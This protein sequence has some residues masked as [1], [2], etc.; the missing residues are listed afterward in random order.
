MGDKKKLSDSEVKDRSDELESSISEYSLILRDAGE[1]EKMAASILKRLATFEA[2][3]CKTPFSRGNGMGRHLNVRDTMA[4]AAAAA[5]ALR[6]VSKASTRLHSVSSILR[7]SVD[8]PEVP[9][10]LNF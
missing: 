6:K 2:T 5:A 8:D 9:S 3:K 7:G 4:A 1:L 10:L